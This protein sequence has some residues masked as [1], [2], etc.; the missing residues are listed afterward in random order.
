MPQSQVDGYQ[1]VSERAVT[2]PRI[3]LII[4]QWKAVLRS[5]VLGGPQETSS[6]APERYLNPHESK[7]A[8]I[9]NETPINDPNSRIP[10]APTNVATTILK[11]TPF[12]RCAAPVILKTYVSFIYM[13]WLDC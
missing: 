5:R 9:M 4:V 11:I 10:T 13:P 1:L 2:F 8:S 6:E 7:A 3:W 12:H